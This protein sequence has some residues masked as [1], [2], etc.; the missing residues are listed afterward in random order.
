MLLHRLAAS[1]NAD[2]VAA[3][4][5]L[6]LFAL[7]GIAG[8]GIPPALEADVVGPGFF[9]TII[10]VAGVALA[11]IMLFRPH[12]GGDEARQGRMF[13]L[14]LTACVPAVLLLAYV[15]SLETIG[16]VTATVLFLAV[17]FRYLGRLSWAR[18][19]FYSVVVTVAVVALFRYGLD[20]KL[21]S[22]NLVRLF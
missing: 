18:S 11:L 7:Y 22:G 4:L 17:T 14:D 6:A 9:P 12:P 20:L 3:L 1:L 15:L 13:D 16:F 10:A 8:Y 2:R 19:G 21:P 5:F